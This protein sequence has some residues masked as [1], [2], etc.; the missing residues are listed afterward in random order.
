MTQRAELEEPRL[1]RLKALYTRTEER[2]LQLH[3]KNK[4]IQICSGA[5]CAFV[6][7]Q[8]FYL[9]TRYAS[10]D[11]RFVC[12]KLVQCAFRLW[13]LMM[14]LWRF[15]HVFNEAVNDQKKKNDQITVCKEK[16]AEPFLHVYKSD[17]T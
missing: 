11:C 12:V 7:C 5:K 15:I 8:P 13:P 10:P 17:T 16:W 9:P 14:T 3:K 2:L 1:A 6:A 4:P